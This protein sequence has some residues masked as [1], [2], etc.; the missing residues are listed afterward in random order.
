MTAMAWVRHI[1]GAPETASGA[2]LYAQRRAAHGGKAQQPH[3]PPPRLR[4]RDGGTGLGAE[5]GSL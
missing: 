4:G 1:G 5:R 2:S 3:R